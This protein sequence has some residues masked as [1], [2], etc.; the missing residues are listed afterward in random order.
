MMKGLAKE[1][2]PQNRKLAGQSTRSAGQPL[3]QSISP[4]LTV[5]SEKSLAIADGPL[6]AGP[7]GGEVRSACQSARLAPS[8]IAFR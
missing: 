3:G 8:P 4:K 7:A 6:Q 1:D 5:C 2:V